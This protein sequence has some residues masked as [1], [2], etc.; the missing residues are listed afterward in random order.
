VAQALMVELLLAGFFAVACFRARAL[1]L[2][3]LAGIA[4]SHLFGLTSR[5][6]RLRRTRWQWFSMVL[7]L[8]LVRVQLGAPLIVEMTAAVEFVLFLALPSVQ[9]DKGVAH[10]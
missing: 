9:P 4:P 8:V 2:P 6:E 10:S 7:L 1:A 5:L 3:N